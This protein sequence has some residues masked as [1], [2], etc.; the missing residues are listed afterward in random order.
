MTEDRPSR[1][2]RD[3]RER[4]AVRFFR[5]I[6]P[7]ARRM[8]PA[9]VPTGAPNV[10]LIVPGRRSGIERTMPVTVL[11]FEGHTYVQATY[12]ASG[13]GRNLQAAEEVTVVHSGG[14]RSSAHPTEVPPD[15]AAAILRRALAPYH[16]S[17]FLRRLLGPRVRPPVGLLRRYRVRID[18]TPQ[19]YL[20]EAQRHPLFELRS[21]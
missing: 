15:E 2:Q 20:D 6:N 7:L 18:D 10:L 1:D 9:G 4:M 17:L 16:R 8:I 21:T 11:D 3:L 14:R 13:W 12:G 19:D 5:V